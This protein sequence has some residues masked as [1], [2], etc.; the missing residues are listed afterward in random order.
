MDILFSFYIFII[1]LFLLGLF[2][3]NNFPLFSYAILTLVVLFLL[4]FPL[5]FLCLIFLIF[6]IFL[7]KPVRIFLVSRF[8]MKIA[9]SLVPQISPTERS[10]LEA[11]ALWIDKDLFSGHPSFQKLMS[12]VYPQLTKEEQDFLNGPVEH[13]CQI[14]DN[15]DIINKKRI[16]QA[17]WDHIK[18]EKFFGM[19]IPKK[20]GGLELSAFAH[21]QVIA[22]LN[23]RSTAVAVTVMVPNSL[24]PAELL[25]HYGTD[26]QR[27]YYLPRLADGREIPCF[28]LTEPEAG[29]DASSIMSSGVVFK[30]EDGKLY[31]RLNWNKRWITLAGV[32]TLMGMAFRL[33]DPDHLL[34]KQEDVGITC[35]LIPSQSEGVVL[36]QRHNPMDVPFYNSPTQGKDV[37]V[38]IDQIIGGPEKAG[39]GWT[40]LMEC[41]GVGR[42]ISLP[43]LSLGSSKLVAQ[44]VGSHA[45]LRK[46][47]GIS[48]GQCEG[49]QEAL[50]RIAGG[51]YLMEAINTYTLGALDSG[52]KPHIITAI[53]K[54]QTTE[55]ARKIINDGMDILGGA[56]ISLGPRNLVAPH[57][58]STPIGI[59]VEGANILTRTLMIFGQG[60][61]RAHPYVFQEIN[62]LEKGDTQVFDDVFWKHIGHVFHNLCRAKFL[63]CTRGFVSRPSGDMHTR[64][65]FRKLAWASALFALMSDMAMALLGGNL[66]RREMLTGRF[67]DVLSHLYMVTAV[68]R[69][70]EAEGRKKED[71]PCMQYA[72]HYCF[73][74]IDMAFDGIFANMDGITWLF[75]Y[76][77]RMGWQLNSV[78]E[79]IDDDLVRRVAL[80][81]LRDGKARKALTKGIYMPKDKDQEQLARIE[82][83]FQVISRSKDTERKIRQAIRKKQLPK[84]K[85]RFVIDEALEKK[86][87]Q[88]DEYDQLKESTHL[89]LDAIQVDAFTQ[90]E[91]FHS[92]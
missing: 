36:D 69:R 50:A 60:A 10:A 23:S 34:G 13:L 63:S 59:T 20:Y 43:A 61:M 64:R 65:Y 76:P 75:K 49:V 29:S 3:Y 4:K 42:G 54:Y 55:M 2:G 48:I 67:A 88:Q 28:A 71:V 5:W 78:K 17:V 8:I 35:A 58:I 46:Q 22:K 53:V 1:W 25:L 82:H 56:G 11:G 74:Q 16:P 41:L 92:K 19:I 40:M 31:I 80:T 33:K 27:E 79:D 18:K 21:A 83:A 44:V 47:F 12:E 89:R 24:G 81:L 91:F 26:Q 62:A 70:Y 52:F 84:K 51:T 37:V 14:C 86:I 57:Y 72:I 73:Q 90:E 66:K 6:L 15:F 39:Q 77:V 32:S 68:L 87:I 30:G 7:I 85:I 9:E 38:S 45:L